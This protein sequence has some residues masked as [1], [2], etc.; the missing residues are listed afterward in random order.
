MTAVNNQYKTIQTKIKT[1][2]ALKAKHENELK[3]INTLLEWEFFYESYSVGNKNTIDIK[4]F[5][6]WLEDNH[7]TLPQYCTISDSLHFAYSIYLKDI[8]K[9]K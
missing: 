2:K 1:L 6:R 4:S 5:N 3:K 7:E 9:I 8:D